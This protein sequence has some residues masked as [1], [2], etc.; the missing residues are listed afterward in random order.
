[1]LTAT[2]RLADVWGLDAWLCSSSTTTATSSQASCF[3]NG[4]ASP[5]I[6]LDGLSLTNGSHVLWSDALQA[7]CV[8]AA[9]AA[10]AGGLELHLQPGGSDVV[11]VAPVLQLGAVEGCRFAVVGLAN[12]LNPGGGVR[13]VC[14]YSDGGRRGFQVS[15]I[16]SGELLLWLPRECQHHRQAVLLDGADMRSSCR[17]D[18]DWLRVPVVAQPASDDD[19]EHVALVV[20]V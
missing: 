19:R 4:Q 13:R 11:T 12:M 8:V 14:G 1:M 2:A 18:G 3:V 6:Q 5:G 17:V 20:C 9:D 16:G 15:F 7:G 10:A